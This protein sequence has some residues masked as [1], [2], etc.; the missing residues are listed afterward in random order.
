MKDRFNGQ[1]QLTAPSWRDMNFAAS[2]RVYRESIRTETFHE[3]IAVQIL[4]WATVVTPLPYFLSFCHYFII[5]LLWN[6]IAVYYK[7]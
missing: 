1:N 5:T 2:R 4:L 6:Y 3:Y 7:M